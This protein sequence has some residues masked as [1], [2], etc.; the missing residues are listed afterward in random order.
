MLKEPETKY[1]EHNTY[2][3]QLEYTLALLFCHILSHPIPSQHK[4]TLQDVINLTTH[5]W[6][7]TCSLKAH[8]A[9]RMLH[10]VAI[11]FIYLLGSL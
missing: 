2:F 9:V 10:P 11:P 7:S 4:N 5:K 3:Y 6:V 1:S 8:F